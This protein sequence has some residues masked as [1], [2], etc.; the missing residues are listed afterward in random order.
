EV[1][2]GG[3]MF[4]GNESAGAPMPVSLGSG[5]LRAGTLYT[6]G[7]DFEGS[8]SVYA[9]GM[10]ADLALT[11]DSTHDL[12]QQIPVVGQPNVVLHLDT[13][14]PGTLGAGYRGLG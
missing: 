9:H 14:M 3:N 7:N 6:D 13:S 4:M 10:V 8:G 2:V 1:D 12:V 11:F 5:T